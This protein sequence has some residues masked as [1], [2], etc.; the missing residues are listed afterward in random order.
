MDPLSWIEVS[1]GALQHNVATFRKRLTPGTSL[2]AVVKANA[3]G[4]G[5]HVVAESIANHVDWFGVNSLDEALELLRDGITTGQGATSLPILIMGFTPHNRADEVVRHGFRQV[6]FDQASAE[7]LAQRAAAQ[8]VTA[9]VHVKL[10]TGTYRLGVGM[11][12]AVAF[13]RH[14]QS[15]PHLEVEGIYTHFAT[16]EDTADD[17]YSAVAD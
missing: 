11:H 16:A 8:N 12:E 10:E 1:R 5:M 17:S 2:L 7:C 13:L 4:H 15:L 6:V 14:L 3:Y 9:A